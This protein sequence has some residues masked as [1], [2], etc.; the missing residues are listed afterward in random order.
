MK[1]SLKIAV[2]GAMDCEI[3]TLKACLKDIQ[4]VEHNKLK[5][6]TGK[7]GNNEI[8]LT[9]SGVGKVCAA[10]NT[11]YIIDTYNPDY[12]IN[13]GVAGGISQE[14]EVGDIVIA[15]SLVQH[16]FDATA[17][18]YV[19]GYACTGGNNQEPT[20]F[21]TD[22]KLIHA[23]ET[24][25]SKVDLTSKFYKGVIATG[26][27]FIGTPAKKDELRELFNATAAEMESSAIVQAANTNNVP[28]LVIR[29]ISDLADCTANKPFAEVEKQMAEVC[30]STIEILLD[31]L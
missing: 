1:N 11:Q 23:F 8:I 14:L 29:A 20:W 30:A 16:D 15:T 28:C 7:I 4:T 18:G 10:I 22:E 6:Y 31:N 9:K 5:V 26:D 12:I 24:A 3:D 25:V 19:K 2:I 17:L 13:T 27:M 21:Y